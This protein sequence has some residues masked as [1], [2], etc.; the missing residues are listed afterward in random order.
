MEELGEHLLDSLDRAGARF[1]ANLNYC[2][3]M[4]DIVNVGAPARADPL[5]HVSDGQGGRDQPLLG[6]E[7]LKGVLQP[8]RVRS[9]KRSNE[10]KFADKLREVVGL[11]IDPPA[12]FGLIREAGVAMP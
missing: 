11:Y 1:G 5:D 10:L 12:R 3:A 2:T 7:H 9:F 4:V 6:A 8:H